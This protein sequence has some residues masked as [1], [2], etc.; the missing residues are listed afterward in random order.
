MDALIIGAGPAGLVAATYLGR[1][2][3]DVVVVDS[4][5]PRADWI[6]VSHNI[7]AFPDGIGGPALL[8]RLR[9]QASRYGARFLEGTVDHLTRD[10]DGGFAASAAGT[11][12]RAERV[13]IAT[14]GVDREPDLPGMR[15]A[16]RRGLVRHCPVCDAYEVTG[17]RVALIGYGKCRVREALML[18]AYTDDL[19]VLTLGRSLDLADEDAHELEA[20]GI[21]I[22]REP[23][24]RL[25]IE[26]NRIAEWHM[27]SGA[28]HRFDTLYSALGWEPRSALARE[29]GVELDE[30]GAIPVDAHHETRIPGLFAAGDVVQ[31]LSQVSVAAG[32]AAIAASAINRSLPY[33]PYQR[34]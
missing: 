19:T 21:R 14:G 2:R 8:G 3:R 32:G 7:P 16:V 13:L 31:G 25:A 29:I 12:I 26:A 5:A 1:F 23:V 34:A 20:A 4:A 30:D 17:Q 27:E 33:R 22:L 6:P 15:D 24:A 11:T 10:P 9:D 18:R 28:S